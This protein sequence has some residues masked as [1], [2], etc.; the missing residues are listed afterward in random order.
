MWLLK[1]TNESRKTQ[2]VAKQNHKG[3]IK[4]DILQDQVDILVEKKCVLRK[5]FTDLSPHTDAV[6]EMVITKWSI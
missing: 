3:S 4:L 6:R 1:T 2:L 5:H